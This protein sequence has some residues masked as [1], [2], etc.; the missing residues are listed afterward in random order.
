LGKSDKNS[1]STT[2]D[3]E[4]FVLVTELNYF[5][6]RKPYLLSGNLAQKLLKC[7]GEWRLLVL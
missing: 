1:P 7:P 6:G 5:T 3:A 4:K 2:T